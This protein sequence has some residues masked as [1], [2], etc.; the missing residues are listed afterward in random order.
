MDDYNSE[1]MQ[2]IAEEDGEIDDF[3]D[4]MQGMEDRHKGDKNVFSSRK[5]KMDLS[6]MNTRKSKMRVKHY[7]PYNESQIRTMNRQMAGGWVSI[8]HF[9]TGEALFSKVLPESE[10]QMQARKGKDMVRKAENKLKSKREEA[11]RKR[12]AWLNE[13][14]GLRYS[15]LT[16]FEMNRRM[17]AYD[18]IMSCF[19]QLCDA[20]QNYIYLCISFLNW[21][22][23][24]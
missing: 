19:S 8:M 9:E 5:S 20:R 12:I 11:E 17:K 4:Y 23:Y 2:E 13:Q 22:R 21:C 6:T 10:A 16:M 7:R 24:L 18:D 1:L 15:G 3:Q 14:G